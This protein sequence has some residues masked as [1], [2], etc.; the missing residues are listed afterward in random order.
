MNMGHEICVLFLIFFCFCSFASKDIILTRIP[1]TKRKEKSLSLTP[2]KS[3]SS[4]SFLVFHHC[5]GSPCNLH[6]PLNHLSVSLMLRT[7]LP[8]QR[9][10]ITWER[11]SHPYQITLLKSFKVAPDCFLTQNP[12]F[13]GR[14]QKF[15]YQLNGKTT[16]W[17]KNANIWPKITKTAYFGPNL[18]V[19]GAGCIN[20]YE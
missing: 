4:S 8:T 18:A 7:H 15:R 13:Y 14:K 9:S 20:M 12:Y 2:T 16:K 11:T 19:F 5:I 1:G 10:Q 6:F 17:A 3:R